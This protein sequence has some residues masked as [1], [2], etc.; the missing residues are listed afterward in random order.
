MS[1]PSSS[2]LVWIRPRPW[3]AWVKTHPGI[4]TLIGLLVLGAVMGW[5]HQY[6]PASFQIS[7]WAI[8][9]ILFAF[10]MRFRWMSLFGPVFVY[11]LVRSTRRS[12]FAALR[13]FYA[14]AMLV[15]LFLAYSSVVRTPA[16][17]LW[18]S[19]W[20]P[21]TV[22][23]KSL[24]QFGEAF[25]YSF[26]A[27][28]FVAVLLFTPICAAGAITEEKERRTLE[29]VLASDLT[30]REVV[31]GKLAARLAYLVLFLLTGLPIL[32]LLQFVGGV[33]PN[34]VIASFLMTAASM[35]SLACLSVAISVFS[36]RTRGAVFFTYIGIVLY[37]LASSYCCALPIPWL[38]AGNFLIA[39]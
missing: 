21:G 4:M 6:I 7:L 1:A 39:V 3:F 2:S 20:Q 18:E 13:S 29:F 30:A 10:F 11:D 26:V 22:P 15:V 37:V 23:V 5:Y 36:N 19:L 32:C 25:F 28:Q 24:A 31:L 16:R 35:T 17:T 9:L 27:V 38:T 33:S 14:G 34:L 12:H 8:L